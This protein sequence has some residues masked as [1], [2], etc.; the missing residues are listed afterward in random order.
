MRFERAVRTG[1]PNL[2]IAAAHELPRPVLLR[3]ALRVLLVLAVADADRYP[4]AAARSARVWWPSESCRSPK[5]SWLSR[6]CRRLRGLIRSPAAR[7]WSSCSSSTPKATVRATSRQWLRA[8]DRL[9]VRR[10]TDLR[11]RGAG[12][13]TGPPTNPVFY[14]AEISSSARVLAA[15]ASTGASEPLAS[16]ADRAMP[17][18]VVDDRVDRGPLASRS[19]A[20]RVAVHET[21]R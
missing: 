8:R 18:A 1:N 6:R 10:L 16:V 5:R 7:R 13:L 21:A 3:D 2:V 20:L 14:E 11:A 12:G 15:P 4:P 19:V 17:V 9:G